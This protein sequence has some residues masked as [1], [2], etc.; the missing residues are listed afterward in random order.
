MCARCAILSPPTGKRIQRIKIISSCRQF[1]PLRHSQH[2]LKVFA[3]RGCSCATVSGQACWRL[4]IARQISSSGPEPVEQ[5]KFAERL[6]VQGN[7]PAERREFSFNTRR[8]RIAHI[9]NE[10]R[11][12]KPCEYA[13]DAGPGW[14]P[15]GWNVGQTN[16]RRAQPRPCCGLCRGQ[17]LAEGPSSWLGAGG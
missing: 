13:P 6:C 3:S 9:H 14:G 10:I 2:L 15:T 5:R 17:W 7:I 16:R 8:R 4:S 12:I 11:L 1:L